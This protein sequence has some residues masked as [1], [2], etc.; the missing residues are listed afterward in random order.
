MSVD[1]LSYLTVGVGSSIVA[2]ATLVRLCVT[3]DEGAGFI[4][5]LRALVL[6]GPEAEGTEV[7]PCM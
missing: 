3:V 5:Q 6:Q 1:M 2:A 4:P 7:Q